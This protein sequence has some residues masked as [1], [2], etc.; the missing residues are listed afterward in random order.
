M[1]RASRFMPKVKE[2]KVGFI[3]L[4]SLPFLFIIIFIL[5]A[6]ILSTPFILSLIPVISAF[7]YFENK[8]TKKKFAALAEK[9]TELGIGEFA[10]S[11]DTKAVDTW[12][13]RAVYEE[14]QNELLTPIPIQ[15][16]DSLFELLEIDEEDLELSILDAIA[17]RTGRSLDNTEAN[18]YF[19]KVKTVRDLVYFM[20]EQ[21]VINKQ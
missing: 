7:I 21:P 9:R 15:A 20:N 14:L 8:K 13:I 17:Q 4:L 18:K 6:S 12:V 11:F 10:R 5:V 2:A 1:K 16:D 19:D 3:G